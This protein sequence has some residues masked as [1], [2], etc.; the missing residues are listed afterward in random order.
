MKKIFFSLLIFTSMFAF[1]QMDSTKAKPKTKEKA[2]YFGLKG[3]PNFSN[4]TNGSSINAG[5]QTGFH[6]G[7]CLMLEVN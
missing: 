6:A 1:S 4:V 2:F 7:C 5:N 3:G